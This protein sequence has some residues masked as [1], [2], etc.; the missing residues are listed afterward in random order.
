MHT[1]HGGGGRRFKIKIKGGTVHRAK[2]TG[3]VIKRGAGLWTEPLG[4]KECGCVEV[5]LGR[6]EK[7]DLR[8]RGQNHV[9]TKSRIKNKLTRP[10]GMGNYCTRGSNRC[11]GKRTAIVR[12]RG[13]GL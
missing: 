4:E 3:N 10:G 11:E 9:I 7:G 2:K 5:H 1:E 13:H 6:G 8:G 12:T